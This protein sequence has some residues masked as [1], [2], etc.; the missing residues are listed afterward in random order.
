MSVKCIK[1]CKQICLLIDLYD[2]SLFTYFHS[3]VWLFCVYLFSF[4]SYLTWKA[5]TLN[6]SQR[7]CL[8]Y[9]CICWAK[10]DFSSQPLIA[11]N[12]PCTLRFIELLYRV[13]TFPPW[14]HMMLKMLL[15]AAMWMLIVGL[16]DLMTLYWSLVNTLRPEQNGWHFADDIFKWVFLNE[17][18]HVLIQI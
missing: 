9:P 5:N 18:C 4:I 7:G 13:V 2:Y 3:F 10:I 11:P 14:N 12:Y 17:N 8:I 15:L 16:H 6:W 1:W